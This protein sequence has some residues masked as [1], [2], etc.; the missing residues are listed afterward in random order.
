ME[1]LGK[2]TGTTSKGDGVKARISACR[3]CRV[4]ETS[5]SLS[6][7]ADMNTSAPRD[8]HPYHLF[9]SSASV[10]HSLSKISEAFRS[11]IKQLHH[12]FSCCSHR[13][14]SLP[15]TILPCR[16]ALGWRANKNWRRS[17]VVPRPR[18]HSWPELPRTITSG[19]IVGSSTG[20]HTAEDDDGAGFAEGYTLDTIASRYC[21]RTAGRLLELSLVSLALLRPSARSW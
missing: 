19:R 3:A 7:H 1:V 15:L 16:K 4:K 9:L 17:M 6:L 21:A 13:C 10:Y 12:D 5:S 2:Q 14:L 8:T 20:L 18:V 11:L